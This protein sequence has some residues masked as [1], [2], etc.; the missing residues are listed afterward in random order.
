MLI[1]IEGTNASFVKKKEF[2]SLNPKRITF[3]DE[4]NYLFLSSL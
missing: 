2:S 1:K 3:I 4:S